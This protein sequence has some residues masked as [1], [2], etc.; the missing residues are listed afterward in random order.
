MKQTRYITLPLDEYEALVNENELHRR[1]KD[2][3]FPDIEDIIFLSPRLYDHLKRHGIGKLD[4]L[5]RTKASDWTRIP[6]FGKKSWEELK[7]L[8][9]LFALD[10]RPE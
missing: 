4:E 6:G 5:E 3:I 1:R 2:G 9:R 8:M 10:F 7:A